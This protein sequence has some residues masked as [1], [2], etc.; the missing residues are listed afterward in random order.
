[1]KFP[2]KLDVLAVHARLVP[3]LAAQAGSGTNPYLIQLSLLLEI[4][5]IT[6]RPM[7]SVVLPRMLII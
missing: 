6:T 4:A 2:E 7:L 5:I 3:R 1:M